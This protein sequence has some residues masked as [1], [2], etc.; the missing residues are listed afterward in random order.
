MTKKAVKPHPITVY[1]FE[2]TSGLMLRASSSS[3]CNRY[4]GLR[5]SPSMFGYSM[6]PG[7]FAQLLQA[8]LCA[9]PLDGAP[10]SE[11]SMSE[12][13]GALGAILKVNHWRF[14]PGTHQS[15]LLLP[16]PLALRPPGRTQSLLSLTMYLYMYMPP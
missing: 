11:S 6:L 3:H 13:S 15:N 7:G 16:M 4:L 14:I 8:V 12:S 9:R 2:P 1:A 10:M 5:R